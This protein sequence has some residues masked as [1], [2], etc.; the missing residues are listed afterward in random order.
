[1]A[2]TQSSVKNFRLRQSTA[3]F[4]PG[5]AMETFLA[6]MWG[7]E[8]NYRI[9]SSQTHT[10]GRAARDGLQRLIHSLRG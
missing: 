5:A 9:E 3:Q 10:K 6:K 1:M 8:S 4:V 7:V 2:Q